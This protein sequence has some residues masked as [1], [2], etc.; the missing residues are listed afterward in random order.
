MTTYEVML[1]LTRAAVLGEEAS[2]PEGLTVDWDE[3]FEISAE[4]G[5]LAWVWDAVCSLP[6]KHLLS[7]LQAINWGLSAQEIWDTYQK[8]HQVLLQMI[9]VCQE[10]HIQLLLL[11]GIGLSQLYPKPESRPCGDIDIYLFDDYEKGNKLFCEGSV[12]E[13]DL[14]SEF[15]IDQVHIE[16]HK[17][18]IFPNTKTKKAVGQYVLDHI[19]DVI[20]SEEGYYVLPLLPNLAY[21]LMHTLNHFNYIDS[22]KV[23]SIRNVIDLAVF[24]Y[25][26][27]SELPSKETYQI[28][29]S[30][31]LDKSFE[32]IVLLSERLLNVDLS[33]YHVGLV[34]TKDAEQIIKILLEKP[35]FHFEEDWPFLKKSYALW[36]R[37]YKLY[38]LT[39]YVPKKPKNGLFRLFFRRQCGLLVRGK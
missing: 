30:L 37:F 17:L 34:K 5:T 7:R 15:H 24:I 23:I 38:P 21:L 27:Q 12:S 13:T 2:L 18:L 9:K 32:M 26:N 4:Q 8:Q 11:K 1:S 20:L 19:D 10:N 6:Q 31:Y 35:C 16:N 39:R 22:S 25:K 33:Q 14:H 3:L 36:N 29:R 28:L